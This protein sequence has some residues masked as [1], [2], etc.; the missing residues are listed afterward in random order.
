MTKGGIALACL[1]SALAL[2]GTAAA[3]LRV[4]VNDDGGKYESGTSWFYPTMA[5]TGLRVNAITLRWDEL[6]PTAI[7]DQPLIEGAIAR[8]Q[9]SGVA[10]ELDIYP[11]HSQALTNGSSCAPS[12]NPEACGNTTRIQQFA[13]WAASVARTF[14]SVREFVVMNECNQPLFVNPQWDTSGQNQSAAICGRALAAAYD[15]LKGVSGG[16]QVWGL[17]LSPRGNDR[18]AAMTN[19]STT[20]VT[21]LGALGTW[22]R[23]FAK[24]TGRTAALMD[25]LDFHPYPVPQSLPFTTGY[26]DQRSVSVTNLPRIYQAFYAAF[27]G[28][29]QRT[30]GKQKG[31]GLPVSLNETGVQT[32]TF[33]KSGYSGSEISANAAGG[34]LDQYATESYQASW[35]RQ[36][37]DLVACD[38]NVAVVNI[39]HLIDESNLSGWQSGMYF[40]DGTPK[41][42]AQVVRDWIARTGGR[43]PG[44]TTTWTAGALTPAPTVTVTVAKAKPKPQA[45]PAKAKGKP[46]KAKTKRVDKANTCSVASRTDVR[47]GPRNRRRCA[48]RLDDRR[49]AVRR[50]RRQ[51]LLPRAGLRHA[52]VDRVRALQR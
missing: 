25:G 21:F 42:S 39:F 45:K 18:P 33:G 1:V 11:L 5:A 8:A 3:D 10:V 16:I 2:T 34:V 26:G 15:A 41:Q 6:S 12:S 46:S 13:G 28:T 27:D 30:I 23:A 14:P 35:Y 32:E 29:S 36:M 31:G 47:Q 50:P 44:R 43:C 38:P 22:F 48:R 20:P 40:A 4:G 24:K 9:S 51:V 37:L 17:G 7:A 49:A 52:L 19:S